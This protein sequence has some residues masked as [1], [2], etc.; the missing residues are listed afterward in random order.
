MKY[1]LKITN[2]FFQK[3]NVF[4]TLETIFLILKLKTFETTNKKT[5]FEFYFTVPIS[6]HKHR[7]LGQKLPRP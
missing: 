5:I 1:F 6:M 4:F 7:G 2:D 3:I